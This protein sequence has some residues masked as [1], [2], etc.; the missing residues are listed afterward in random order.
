M[1][2]YAL[3]MNFLIRRKFSRLLDSFDFMGKDWCFFVMNLGFFDF[4]VKYNINNGVFKEFFS[5]SFYVLF[6]EWIFYF[7]STVGVFMFKLRELGRRD[8]VDFLLK[9]FFVFKINLDGNG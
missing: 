2:I 7:E 8:A 4:V 9:V 6:R 3:D 5:S 1:D